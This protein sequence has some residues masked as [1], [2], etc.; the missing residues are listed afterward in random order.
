MGNDTPPTTAVPELLNL[1][2]IRKLFVPLGSRTLFRFI[3]TG[4]F[5]SADV[6]IGA[7]VRLWRRETIEQWISDRTEATR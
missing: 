1:S 7:K 3:S 2:L 5:P 6:K 4:Q